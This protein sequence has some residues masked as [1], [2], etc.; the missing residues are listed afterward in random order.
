LY[1]TA[2]GYFCY[3]PRLR[4]SRKGPKWMNDRQLR[5]RSLKQ[6]GFTCSCD[7]EEV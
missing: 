3:T 1:G 5:R 7:V 4:W 6:M 2:V